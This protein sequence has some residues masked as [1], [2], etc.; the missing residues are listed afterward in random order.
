M[1]ERKKRD[2]EGEID[3]LRKEEGK[4]D[5]LRANKKDRKEREKQT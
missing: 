5:R 1:Q 4:K 3:T 2:R